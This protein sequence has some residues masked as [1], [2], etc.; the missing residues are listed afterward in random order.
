[1]KK[2]ALV[3]GATSGIGRAT[4]IA[5]ADEGYNLIITG[6]RKERLEE[7]K[8]ML[9]IT[10]KADVLVLNFD[11]RDREA[12]QAA[13]ES[14][15]AAW[16]NIDVLV[17]NA[18][19]AV[20]LNPIQEGLIEDWERMI[21]PNVKG[22]LYVSRA[23][24][25]LMCAR[26]TGHI[27]NLC[28]TAGKEVYIV[29][30]PYEGIA[31]EPDK[32][33]TT[34]INN[35]LG[36]IQKNNL[37]SQMTLL[38]ID[39]VAAQL[40]QINDRYEQ[41]SAERDKPKARERIKESS[42]EL[43]ASEREARNSRDYET[44]RNQTL[45]LDGV[46]PADHVSPYYTIVR[47]NQI[48]SRERRVLSK[49]SSRMHRD[50]CFRSVI[51]KYNSVETVLGF[52]ETEWI[53]NMRAKINNRTAT[54]SEIDEYKKKQNE[55]IVRRAQH[56][57]FD[58]R[59]VARERGERRVAEAPELDVLLA[60]HGER[61]R[62]RRDARRV[63][64]VRRAPQRGLELGAR[65][66]SGVNERLLRTRAGLQRTAE[67]R[68]HRVREPLR[69]GSKARRDERQLHEPR[70]PVDHHAVRAAARQRPRV[71]KVLVGGVAAIRE[72][73]ASHGEG[74]G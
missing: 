22:L 16:K 39:D 8:A 15:P 70:R 63:E 34:L 54:Q 17:N 56:H 31:K 41:L 62:G 14:I 64:R 25:P 58:E 37:S 32:Q 74:P 60:R 65:G 18:G 3:T 72:R 61:E 7:L 69:V 42:A 12:V 48:H 19:L 71:G 11:V 28:S 67:H 4:A 5:L 6:R 43:R 52:K 44:M 20:G 1:M 45:R 36:D 23:V 27:V 33:K 40:Q 9:G 51:E 50:A 10:Y 68:P 24:A 59:A 49:L 66:V 55:L 57:A 13:I 29:V 47:Y 53:R 21:D 46:F 38:G 35:M 73:E 2:I 26:G 30:K